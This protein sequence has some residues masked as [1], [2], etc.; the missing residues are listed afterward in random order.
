MK[1]ARLIV[2]MALLSQ[3]A[4]AATLLRGLGPEPDSLDIHQVQGLPGIQVLREIREGLTTFDAAGEVTPGVALNWEILEDGRLYRFELRENARW[5]NGDAVTADDFVRA[6]R[7]ALSPGTLARTA[8]L[9]ANVANAGVSMKGEVEASEIG[10]TAVAANALEIRLEAATPWFLEVLA[11]PVAFPLHAEGMDKPLEAPVNGAFMIDTV[12]PHAMIRLSRNPHF[13]ASSSVALDTV[14]YLPIEDPNS[15]L[16]RYRAGELHM[17]ETIPAGRHDWLKTYMGDELKVH[18]Y[19]GSFWLGLNLKREPFAR[20]PDLRRALSLAVDRTVIA[21]LV[22]G[23]GELPAWSIVPPGIEG[24]T[25]TAL[26]DSELSQ[27]AREHEA[28]RLYRAAGYGDREALELELRYN[29]SSQHRKI[30]LAVSSMW[31]QVLGVK[32]ELVNEEW[33][34]FVN[35]RRQGALTQ[36][37][38]G[39]WIADYADPTS[40]LDLF[41]SDNELNTTFY[42]NSTFDALMDQA[43]TLEGRERMQRLAQ[44]EQLLMRDTPVIPLFFYVSRHLLKPAVSG[45]V[46]NVRDIHLSRYMGVEDQKS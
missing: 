40:F 5:S 39:G 21:R 16:S 25:P 33:K 44:A 26:A 31:R 43:A 34:V 36:V 38:R 42:S 29:T 41:R 10:I 28:R 45:F 7:R 20:N 13:H 8:S 23:A 2:L 27:E 12:S 15:E 1:I 14:E 32:T 11:H 24:F 30:A 4:F 3:D 17:T 6:W 37:F 19:I 9:L 22:I 35:N 46:P 18:P